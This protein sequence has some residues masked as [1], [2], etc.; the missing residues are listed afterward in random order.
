[1]I[2][3]ENH[4]GIIEISNDYFSKLIGHAVSEC[5]GVSGMVAT[6]ATQEI[7]AFVFRR[8]SI[9]K[10]VRVRSHA[11]KLYID[12]HIAV[13]YGFNIAEIVKSII[14]KVR[15]VVE[16]TTSLQVEKVN[17]YVD[18]MKVENT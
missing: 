3:I 9:D 10:G 1:M 14:N 18:T 16:D 17:V 13:S 8:D 7:N 5:F 4:L 2:R 15:Y 12:L 6:N 11:G